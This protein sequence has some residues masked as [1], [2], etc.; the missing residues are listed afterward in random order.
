MNSI[1][2]VR[3][4]R[5]LKTIVYLALLFVI[6]LAIGALVFNQ[7]CSTPISEY[8]PI[9]GTTSPELLAAQKSIGGYFRTEETTYI[10]FPEWYLVFNPQE[11]A[12]HLE[13]KKPSAFPYFASIAQFWG[14]YCKVYG[15]SKA[16]YPFNVGN[17]VVEAV[18]GT[19]FTVE[20]VV[21]GIYENTVGQVSEVLAGYTS[22]EDV[23]AAH[24]AKEYGEFIPNWPWYEFPY[25]EKF[26]G[27]WTETSFFGK[28]IIRKLERKFFLSIEYGV[29]AVYAQ[30]IKK[31]TR[32][33]FG[34]AATE[35]YATVKT[36]PAEVYA[37]T[38]IKEFKKLPSGHTI[39]TLPHYQGFTDAVPSLANKGL[40]FVDVSG[41]NE[42]L[43]SA[44]IPVLSSSDIAPGRFLFSMPI[45]TEYSKQRIVYQVPTANLSEVILLL[46]KNG[47][48]V[49]HLFD[50]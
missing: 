29:K 22:E 33:A 45:L 41:N 11:Y 39:V 38:R 21:K 50:Y 36:P 4:G 25:G 8:A 34:I 10:T 31:A 19:S 23:F 7:K 9:T 49:E 16:H 43:M 1:R 6:V 44:V 3:I 14:S 48:A 37:D 15:I 42:I 12:R 13:T 24:V 18:I 30:I 5:A 27:L 26:T 28:D 17:H 35:V 46:E 47:G 40:Q 2:D 32:S 20:F